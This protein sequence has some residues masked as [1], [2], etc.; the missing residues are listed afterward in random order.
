MAG[1]S[2]TTIAARAFTGTR[3]GA[4]RELPPLA[5]DITSAAYG[6]NNLGQVVGL[7]GG[8]EGERAVRWE[9]NG[10][11]TALPGSQSSF[12]SRGSSI[13]ERGDIAGVIGTPS[14]PRPV[15]WPGGQAPTQLALLPVTPPARRTRSMHGATPW[16][17]RATKQACAV[18]PCGP[19]AA[20]WST[21]AHCRGAI[22]ARH[23]GTTPSDRSLAHPAAARGTGPSCGARVVGSRI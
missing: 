18:P 20:R 17:T 19:R 6:M 13:N 8:A 7:S 22:P 1:T 16:A 11:P 3:A 15:L 12:G 5:G 23:S 9:A 14:G 21:L 2:S 4:V 10:T